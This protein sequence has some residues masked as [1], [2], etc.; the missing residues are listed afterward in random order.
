MPPLFLLLT[1]RP[2]RRNVFKLSLR[3]LLR[4]PTYGNGFFSR[5]NCCETGRG[6]AMPK[7]PLL[8]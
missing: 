2:K 3:R 5:K 8:K 1:R 6:T 7:L 4:V